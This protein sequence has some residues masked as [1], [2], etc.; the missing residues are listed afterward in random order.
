MT[1]TAGAP[2]R[3]RR[4]R[5]VVLGLSTVPALLILLAQLDPW[6]IGQL[7]VHWTVQA[8]LLLLPALVLLRRHAVACAAILVLWALA[9]WPWWLAAREP[10]LPLPTADALPLSVASANVAAWNPWRAQAIAA[11]MDAATDVVCLVEATHADRH[12]LADDPRFPYQAWSD[13][14]AILSRHPFTR[15]HIAQ[16]AIVCADLPWQGQTLH[17]LALHTLSPTTP[18]RMHGRNAE[19]VHLASLVRAIDGPVLVMGDFNLTVGD[20]AWRQLSRSSGLERSAAEVATWP[21]VFGGAGIGIDHLLGRDLSLSPLR[22]VWLWGSDHR[23][24]AATVALPPVA[25][26][27]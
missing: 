7:W 3:W 16:D 10:R 11:A 4:L 21:S 1:G 8:A 26:D 22:P 9:C 13:A 27:R 25:H 18:A 19:L 15:W 5:A 6:F 2:P 12:R 20:H 24:I 17:L 14:A 23:G